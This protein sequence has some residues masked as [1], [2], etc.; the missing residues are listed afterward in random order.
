MKKFFID[1]WFLIPGCV[2][3]LWLYSAPLP[4]P[5]RPAPP[6]LPALYAP[7]PEA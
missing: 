7:M 5:H 3:L 2:F 1:M 6:K 4:C